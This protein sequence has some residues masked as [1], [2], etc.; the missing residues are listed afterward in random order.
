MCN[1]QMAIDEVA[2]LHYKGVSV[3]QVCCYSEISLKNRMAAVEIKSCLVD[4]LYAE[5]STIPQSMSI[6][7]DEARSFH[8][9]YCRVLFMVMDCKWSKLFSVENITY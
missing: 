9:M 8:V 5:F 6:L 3:S 2:W 4:L 7:F 1:C